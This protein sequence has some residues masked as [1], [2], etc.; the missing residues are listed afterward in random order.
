[1]VTIVRWSKNIVSRV[2]EKRKKI[3]IP[4]R[5]RDVVSSDAVHASLSR[6]EFPE[7]VSPLPCIRPRPASESFSSNSPGWKRVHCPRE[8]AAKDLGEN[9]WINGRPPWHKRLRLFLSNSRS[10]IGE[11]LIPSP[12]PRSL[13]HSF[14][15]L[16]L[17][18]IFSFPFFYL[19][20]E[21]FLCRRC[22]IFIHVHPSIVRRIENL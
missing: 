8:H 3:I 9:P 18:S 17:F 20:N 19:H 4:S 5:K 12:L 13:S 2:K 21:Y 6:A 22:V 10:K 16:F 1:M 11:Q 7:E 15:S 14:V